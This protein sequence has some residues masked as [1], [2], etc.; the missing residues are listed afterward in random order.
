MDS[1]EASEAS[2]PGSTPG[3]ATLKPMNRN[4]MGFLISL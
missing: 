4:D 3:G 1:M 2:D